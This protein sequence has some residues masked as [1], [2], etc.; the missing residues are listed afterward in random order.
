[1]DFKDTPELAEFR[2][3]ARRWL[4]ANAKRR[5][6]TESGIE[7]FGA[8]DGD[9]LAGARQMQALLAD[10]GWAG[11]TWP[12]SYGGRGLTSMHDI[13][14]QQEAAQFEL[15]TDIFGIGIGMGGPTIIS[16]GTEEQKNLWLRPLLCGEEIWCQLFSEPEAGSDV[17]AVRTAASR[18]GDDWI[19]EGQKVWTS[20]ARHSKWGML[21]ART[22]PSVPKH[23]GL[24]YF[25]IDMEQPG[26]ECRP[27]RQMTGES[28]FNEVFFN[29]ARVPSG[30]LVGQVGQGW[31]VATTT[32]MN[33]RLSIGNL[34]IRGQGALSKVLALFGDLEALS[35]SRPLDRD[36]IRRRMTRLYIDGQVLRYMTE[37]LITR[38]GRGEIPTAEGS[39]AKLGLTRIV[40]NLANLVMLAQGAHGMLWLD[41][42]AGAWASTFLGY[43]GLRIAGG[44]DEV[45]KNLVAERVLGLPSEPRF[46]KDVPFSALT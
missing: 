13:V 29:E 22:D 2:V 16:W 25:I 7:I 34:L 27:L 12:E 31:A 35:G 26:V 15:D 45:M 44:T 18:D 8:I 24:S 43:P 23:A 5:T 10:A 4:E 14:W 30:N 1:M 41:D 20:G 33:E 9:R 38:V 11:L 19:I 3:Q 32:L 37:R 6:G 42:E 28:T 40:G 17:A 39:A 21:L 46:D 36:E